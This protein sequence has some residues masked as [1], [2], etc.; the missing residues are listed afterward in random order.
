LIISGATAANA[1]TYTCV[2]SNSEGQVTSGG[3]A[4][5]VA[6][7]ANPG[8][9]INISCRAVA[10]TG[11]NI[12]IAGFYVGGPANA[13]DLP[14]LVRAT[15]PTLGLAPYNVPAVLPDPK[16]ELFQSNSDGSSTLLLTDDV[17]GGN[18]QI[19]TVASSVGAF[20]WATT[21]LDSAIYT[22]VAQGA[23]TAQVAGASGD[24]GVALAE[25]YDATPGGSYEA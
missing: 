24:T 11:G 2:A 7:T 13:G 25:V 22:S 19:E 15:G 20:P 17:W 14:V 5:T 10:G 3:A 4:L 21:S 9:L 16:L 1:G 8:R 18:S 23:Y 6:N 12:I